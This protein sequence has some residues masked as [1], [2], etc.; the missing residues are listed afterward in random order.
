MGSVR[1]KSKFDNWFVHEVV[2][3]GIR[4]TVDGTEGILA[5]HLNHNYVQMQGGMVRQGD[6]KEGST[7]W[8]SNKGRDWQYVIGW[9]GFDSTAASSLCL[10]VTL[11]L[12]CSLDVR[13]VFPFWG[14]SAAF[15]VDVRLDG[16]S[17]L[18][19]LLQ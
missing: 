16:R 17:S 3:A 19:D 7:F 12:P 2:Q 11:G 4:D 6:L 10:R 8:M 14:G 1:G 5:I 15:V 18:H 9:L 13:R